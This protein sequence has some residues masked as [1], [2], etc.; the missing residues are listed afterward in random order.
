M[1]TENVKLI[2]LAYE[3][4][5]TKTYSSPNAFPSSLRSKRALV[6]NKVDDSE[7]AT[8]KDP[9]VRIRFCGCVVF[10]L[11]PLPLHRAALSTLSPLAHVRPDIV[12]GLQ[13][14]IARC[15]DVETSTPMT[16]LTPRRKR[17]ARNA[18]ISG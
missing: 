8:D 18:E 13:C 1:D 12:P 9:I 7:A 5:P 3:N 2:P 14:I 10:H 11:P 4:L 6:Q 16:T 15:L 17:N